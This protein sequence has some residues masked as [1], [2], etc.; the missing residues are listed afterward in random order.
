[1]AAFG[2]VGARVSMNEARHLNPKSHRSGGCTHPDL[3]SI[4]DDPHALFREYG[5]TH[6]VRIRDRIVMM[7]EG[8]VRSL[9]SRFDVR[10]WT[11]TEDLTQV[12]FMALLSAIEAYD[13]SR[14]AAFSS[15]AV[16][17]IV[18]VIKH[19]LRDHTW[20]LKV[21]RRLREL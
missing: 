18:G 17:T 6:D 15:F 3:A 21:P 16:P 19:Y 1:M 9:A 10:G 8:L 11:S 7:H 13:P 12:G 2:P 5:R 14:G 4:W 20:G